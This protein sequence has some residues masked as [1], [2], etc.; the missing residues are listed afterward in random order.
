MR[1]VTIRFHDNALEKHKMICSRI[2]EWKT[3]VSSVIVIY[4]IRC[5]FVYF[6]FEWTFSSSILILNFLV[7]YIGDLLK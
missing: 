7:L 2:Y 3:T 6:L 5:L 4:N 1:Q